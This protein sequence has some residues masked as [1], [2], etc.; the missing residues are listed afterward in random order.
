MSVLKLK[1]K[2][3]NS[4]HDLN[5]TVIDGFAGWSY[6][7]MEWS[8]FTDK[9]PALSKNPKDKTVFI[10]DNIPK[11]GEIRTVNVRTPFEESVGNEFFMDYL[12]I[13][14]YLNGFNTS[15][16]FNRS[17]IVKCRFAELISSDGYNAWIKV[18]VLNTIMFSEL[19]NTFNEYKTDNS[20]EDF[21][22]M[23]TCIDIDAEDA[24]WKLIAWNAQ[25][26][27]YEGKAIH[28][29]NSNIPHIVW[30][31]HEDFF[32]KVSYFGNIV[33]V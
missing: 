20:L 1:C 18:E 33:K 4:Y 22:T 10:S 2:C 5:R 32:T 14:V 24:P 29:D 8:D 25:G 6:P 27:I 16:D 21:G 17:A 30:L 3:C 26:D 9:V 28:T 11:K 12:P 15:M 19:I 7:C 31:Y 23:C 13:S